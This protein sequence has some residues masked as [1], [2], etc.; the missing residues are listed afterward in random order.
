MHWIWSLTIFNQEARWVHSFSN[1][2]T[3]KAPKKYPIA[4]REMQ[5]I[6]PQIVMHTAT[7]AA[8]GAAPSHICH[9][10]LKSHPCI[11]ISNKG[12]KSFR[13]FTPKWNPGPIL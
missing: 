4:G 2:P 6:L 9:H 8:A 10:N 1:Y 3:N 12:K 7:A 5:T 13:I 11:S